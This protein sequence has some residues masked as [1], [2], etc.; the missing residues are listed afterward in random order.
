MD[1]LTGSVGQFAGTHPGQVLALL[2]AQKLK[3]V[4]ADGHGKRA[5]DVESAQISSNH[6]KK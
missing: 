5:E 4:F 2:G 6:V 1:Q 3:S